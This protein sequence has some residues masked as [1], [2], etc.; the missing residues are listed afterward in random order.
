MQSRWGY[1]SQFLGWTCA[2]GKDLI[3]FEN[4]IR[5]KTNTWLLLLLLLL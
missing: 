1:S 5:D 3:T 2:C 4:K